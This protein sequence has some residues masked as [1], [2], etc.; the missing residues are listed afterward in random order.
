MVSSC[1]SVALRLPAQ[2][3]VLAT[4]LLLLGIAEQ[5][6]VAFNHFTI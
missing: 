6:R 4:A 2:M 5:V 3:F 1:G